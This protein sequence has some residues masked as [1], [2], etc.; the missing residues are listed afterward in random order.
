M[1]CFTPWAQLGNKYPV[2]M[3]ETERPSRTTNFDTD[4]YCLGIDH[5]TLQCHEAGTQAKA[6]SKAADEGRRHEAATHRAAA[7]ADALAELALAVG[8]RAQ[9]CRRTGRRY[10]PCAPSSSIEV[11][12]PT[13]PNLMP[14]GGGMGCRVRGPRARQGAPL[15]QGCEA[16]CA[17]R[18]ELSCG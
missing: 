4:Y 12:S 13:H 9:P 15:T 16:G 5:R 10:I 18:C 3:G 2:C 11:P 6:F 8:P 7:R 17:V 14:G 1:Q